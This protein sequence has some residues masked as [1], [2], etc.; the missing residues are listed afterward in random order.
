MPFVNRICVQQFK[1]G[2]VVEVRDEVKLLTNSSTVSNYES[3][4]HMV[5]L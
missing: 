3:S 5:F 4:T 1:V 2:H